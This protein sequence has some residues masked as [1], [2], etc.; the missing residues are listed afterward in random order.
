MEATAASMHLK[1]EV[2]KLLGPQLH[3]ERDESKSVLEP[4]SLPN[5]VTLC[6]AESTGNQ[7]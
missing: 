1:T 5:D 2:S 3:V 7:L 4:L 6:N